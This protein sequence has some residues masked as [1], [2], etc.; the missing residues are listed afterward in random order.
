MAVNDGGLTSADELWAEVSHFLSRCNKPDGIYG[1]LTLLLSGEDMI[2]LEGGAYGM[3]L[4]LPVPHASPHPE[5]ELVVNYGKMETFG[6]TGEH[7]RLGLRDTAGKQL[8]NLR[9]SDLART[10]LTRRNL[11]R[12]IVDIENIIDFLEYLD[13][14]HLERPGFETLRERLEEAR[15]YLAE[16]KGKLKR[17]AQAQNRLEG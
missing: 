2:P 8:D 14:E 10:I 11:P 17:L 5:Q 13:N 3:Q 4:N 9:P 6:K 1:T 16:L 7:L 15:G 12:G